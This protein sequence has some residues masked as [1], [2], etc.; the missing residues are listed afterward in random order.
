M[1]RIIALALFVPLAGCVTTQVQPLAPNVV[2]IDTQAGGALYAGTAVPATMRAAAKATLEAGYSHFRLA[3]PSS[4]QGSEVVGVTGGTSGYA[5]GYE[6]GLLRGGN[7]NGYNSNFGSASVI[8][9]PTEHSAATVYMFH[10]NEAGAKN[11]FNA[12]DILAKYPE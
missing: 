11:A 10:A 6:P 1:K 12:R 4:G 7:Y 9:A 2:R 8:R 3:D 5:S